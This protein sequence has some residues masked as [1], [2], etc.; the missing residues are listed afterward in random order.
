MSE[1]PYTVLGVKRDATQDDISRAYRALAKK[2]HPDLNPGDRKAEEQFKKVAAANDILGSPEKRAK[3]DNGEIDAEGHE[4]Q[5]G[6][7]RQH[8]EAQ[9]DDPYST[10][11]G[12]ADLEDVLVGGRAAPDFASAA[13]TLVT[14]SRSIF[15][16]PS[17]AR[18]GASP[19]RMARC[20]S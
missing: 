19:C 15:W 7:Y 5:R 17:M 4:R 13:P 9:G 20:A 3:F 1:D 12:F 18:S 8:A 11:S 14:N 10:Q 6:F 16:R 2:H